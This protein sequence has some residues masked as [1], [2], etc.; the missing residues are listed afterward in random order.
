MNACPKFIKNVNYVSGTENPRPC[1][2]QHVRPMNYDHLH[3]TA[4]V[5]EV[6]YNVQHQTWTAHTTI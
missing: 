3:S 4:V 1:S 5:M 2:K 6:N